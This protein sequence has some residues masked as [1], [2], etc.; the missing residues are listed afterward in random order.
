MFDGARVPGAPE[1]IVATRSLEDHVQL[2]KPWSHALSS[3]ALK[4]YAPT[5]V[6]RALQLAESLEKLAKEQAHDLKKREEGLNLAK[7]MQWF[8]FDFMGDMAYVRLVLF[9]NGC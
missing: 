1:N 2:R 3:V 8:S 6:R 7:W 5:I 9:L 4:D